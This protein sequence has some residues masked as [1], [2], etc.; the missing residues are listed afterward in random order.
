MKFAALVLF[1]GVMMLPAQTPGDAG[2]VS[3]FGIGFYGGM[4]VH[5]MLGGGLVDYI[6]ASS[7]FGD[8]TSPAGVSVDFF[9]GAEAEVTGAWG[10][11]AEYAY[12]FKSYSFRAPSGALHDLF[13]SLKM[14]TL[15][16]QRYWKGRGYR[17]TLGAGIGYHAGTVE[18]TVST[19]G[20]TTV[21]SAEGPAI[22]VEAAG[23]TA[24]DGH[25]YGYISLRAGHEFIGTVTDGSGAELRNALRG[26]KATLGITYGGVRFGLM[27]H[28]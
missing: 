14:P 28:I 10:L 27:Y 1:A 26:T 20:V 4:G 12:H 18:Q 16:V 25:L 2:T 6:N 24:F 23:Q 13:A 3:P 19:F 21:H 22:A 17:F 8:E 11:R 15:F 7:A 5:G 9:G